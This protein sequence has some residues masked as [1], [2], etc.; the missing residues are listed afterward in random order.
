MRCIW[1]VIVWLLNDFNEHIGCHQLCSLIVRP[2][3]AI[4]DR[5]EPSRSLLER[6]WIGIL[7]HLTEDLAGLLESLKLGAVSS[8]VELSLKFLCHAAVE[9][10]KLLDAVTELALIALAIAVSLLDEYK[11]HVRQHL[12]KQSQGWDGLV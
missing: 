4:D 5:G 11:F 7:L 1:R 9:L 3:G 8:H 12:L 6:A 2:L 10:V